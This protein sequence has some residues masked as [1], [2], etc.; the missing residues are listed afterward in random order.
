MKILCISFI[1]FSIAFAKSGDKA[2]NGGDAIICY[3][4][5]VI[6]GDISNKKMIST[7]V[8][9]YW[10]YSQMM[11]ELSLD[12]GNKKHYLE[13]VDYVLNR[14]KMV[15]T[16]RAEVLLKRLQDKNLYSLVGRG[17]I[18]MVDDSNSYLRP[19]KSD[20]CIETQVAFQILH[21]RQ[22][23]S[24]ILIDKEIFND[25]NEENKAGLILHELLYEHDIKYTKATDSDTIRWFNY[26]ISSDILKV[27]DDIKDGYSQKY[28]DLL[29]KNGIDYFNYSKKRSSQKYKNANTDIKSEDIK[30][31]LLAGNFD[32]IQNDFVFDGKKTISGSMTINNVAPVYFSQTRLKVFGKSIYE[33]RSDSE[34]LKGK[35][36]I[37]HPLIRFFSEN[38]STNDGMSILAKEIILER[39]E[40]LS[41]SEVHF[42]RVKIISDLDLDLLDVKSFTL[43]EEKYECVDI[44]SVE[45]RSNSIEKMSGEFLR[46]STKL[47]ISKLKNNSISRLI[48]KKS[49]ELKIRSKKEEIKY[50]QSIMIEHN[51]IFGMTYVSK[52]KR[53]DIFINSVNVGKCLKKKCLV[54]LEFNKDFELVDGVI[55]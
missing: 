16:Y 43:D 37:D 13:K 2:G 55:K 39:S 23:Q 20:H 36:F 4:S 19:S 29:V 49:K 44:C 24:K 41:F 28:A 45:I 50:V 35:V 26:V 30:S 14:L 3:D 33:L 17:Q 11:N 47:F 8:K 32:I 12:L 6:D 10:E 7:K 18:L 15:D 46:R 5:P 54:R 1:V 38:V 27:F 53:K 40:L 52:S 48:L 31:S 22:F 25:M 34:T 51:K 21:P 9:D 42:K